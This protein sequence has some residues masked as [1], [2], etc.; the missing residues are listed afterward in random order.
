MKKIAFIL[1]A[2]V[3]SVFQTN[4]QDKKLL[5]AG[6]DVPV[7]AVTSINANELK[8]GQMIE[9]ATADDVKLESGEIAIPK[10]SQV[11]ARVR[12]SLKQRF[13]VNEKKRIVIDIKEVK[14]P[15][16]KKV[17]LGNG[18]VN[19]TV[20]KNIGDM[21][22]APLKIVSS[23]KYLIPTDYVMHAKVEVSQD[24]SK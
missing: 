22:G 21:V 16:G 13:L 20:S 18:V 8:E 1:I 5:V 23:K 12:T 6:T 17:A 24:I 7:V 4:A 19:F 15:N 9:L 2:L 11:S 3:A 10:G 14:L